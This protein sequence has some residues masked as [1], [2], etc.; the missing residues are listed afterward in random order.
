MTPADAI[1]RLARMKSSRAVVI[2]PADELA[3]SM[4]I[5]ALEREV[6]RADVARREA[7]RAK[8]EQDDTQ[9][10]ALCPPASST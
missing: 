6:E 2:Q 4:G 1:E 10:T 8:R 5:A 3:I 9:E 7:A